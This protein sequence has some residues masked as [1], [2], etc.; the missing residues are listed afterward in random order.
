MTGLSY[1]QLINEGVDVLRHCSDSP[2]IDCEVL[3]QATL[4]KNLAWLIAH[5]DSMATAEH[6]KDFFNALQRRQK[7]EPIAYILGY[8]EFWSLNLEV[9]DSVLVPRPDTETLVEAALERI[10]QDSSTNILDMGTGSGAIALAIA[11][12]RPQSRVCAV[13]IC[14]NALAVAQRNAKSHNLDNVVLVQSNWFDSIPEQLF[15]VIVS[16]PPYV[17][18]NDPHLTQGDLPAEPNLALI[19]KEDGLGDIRILLEQAKQY[20]QKPTWVLIEHGSDQAEQVRELFSLQGY[21]Q[22]ETHTDLNKLA[23]CTLGCL[24]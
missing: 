23:R 8:K 2:R 13:D 5:G 17:A 15:D 18:P 19:G 12:E 11:K 10:P 6:I 24:V 21:I 3:L 14:P 20:A 9:N 1:Q 16:N 22:I 7:G 4:N